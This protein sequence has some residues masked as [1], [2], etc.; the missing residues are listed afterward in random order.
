MSHRAAVLK[1]AKSARISILASAL[2]AAQKAADETECED[3][4]SCCLD[5]V[6]VFLPPDYTREIRDAAQDR[7]KIALDAPSRSRGVRG[8]RAIQLRLPGMAQRRTQAAR[9]AAAAF[10]AALGEHV[11][12]V[13]YLA[14]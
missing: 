6:A 3:A 8:S 14:D 11:A 2:V 7:A 13:V 10:D 1:D 4:G 12:T 5:Y 9:R